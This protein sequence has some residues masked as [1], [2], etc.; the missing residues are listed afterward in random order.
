MQTRNEVKILVRFSYI[1]DEMYFVACY[2]IVKFFPYVLYVYID[3]VNT[4]FSVGGM[5]IIS[6]VSFCHDY[7]F[8]SFFLN[9]DMHSGR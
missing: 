5:H 1:T 6:V 7:S 9:P 4:D 8:H 3:T 2:C